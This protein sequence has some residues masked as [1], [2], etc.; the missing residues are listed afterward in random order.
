MNQA[1]KTKGFT[2]VELVIVVGIIALLAA[3]ALPS[4]NSSVAKTRRADAK[5][6]LMG[7]AQA[8]ERHFTVKNTYAGA[9]SGGG[10]TGSPAIFPTESP[11]EGSTKFYDLTIVS[12]DVNGFTLR[13]TPKG[14]QSTDGNLE[15]DNTGAKR[16]K[17][18]AGWD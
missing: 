15:I 16:W 1:I 5:S 18:N 13:A 11:I 6:A 7:F 12:A 10:D 4:Y 9:A 3:I 8:M 2:L 14:G 17:G